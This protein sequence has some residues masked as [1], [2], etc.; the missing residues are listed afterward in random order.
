MHC[1]PVCQLAMAKQ[2]EETMALWN[3]QLEAKAAEF[4]ELRST[5]APRENMELVRQKVMEELE[6]TYASRLAALKDE[7]EKYQSMFFEV[8]RQHRLLSAEF[9]RYTVQA[10]QE[11]RH[12]AG[13]W[14]AVSHILVGSGGECSR[15][16]QS[17]HRGADGAE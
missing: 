6:V 2:H 7:S 4:E 11:V 5:I 13:G 16:Q 15:S 9:E 17:H 3:E 12:L 8:R 14:L 1:C 10:G